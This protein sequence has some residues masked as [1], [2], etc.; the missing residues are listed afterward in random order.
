MIRKMVGQCF[1]P[2][3]TKNCRWDV[4]GS[5]IQLSSLF[6]V[7][8][9]GMVDI[10][11]IGTRT[12]TT[13]TTP[14]PRDMSGH[15]FLLVESYREVVGMKSSLLLIAGERREVVAVGVV[16]FFSLFLGQ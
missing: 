14:L 11:D 13:S 9:R 10:V 16:I 6:S 7:V 2:D 3:Q 1:N 5:V 12:S 4:L 8:G 15:L